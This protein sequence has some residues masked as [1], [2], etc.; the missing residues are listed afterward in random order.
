M[1]RE[2]LT[3]AKDYDLWGMLSAILLAITIISGWFVLVRAKKK[4]RNLNFFTSPIRDQ[5]NY[6]LRITVEIRNYTGRSVVISSPYFRYKQLRPDEKARGDTPTGDYEI[7]FP[8]L[9]GQMLEEVEYLLRAKESV[10]TWIPLD[11]KHNDQEVREAVEK[12]N[13]GYLYCVCTW[14]DERPKI[15]KLRRKI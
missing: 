13:V 12:N 10:S 15:H 9:D 5:Q 4:V 8:G 3:W 1:I 6:P 11:P 14:L 7:K 2:F